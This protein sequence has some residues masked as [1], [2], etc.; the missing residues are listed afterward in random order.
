MKI[1]GQ[2]AKNGNGK[3]KKIEKEKEEK[4]KVPSLQKIVSKHPHFSFLNNGKIKCDLTKHEMQPSIENFNLYLKSKS[5]KKGVEAQYDISE[6]EEYLIPHKDNPDKLLFC[7]LT[8]AKISKKKSAIE[9]HVNGKKFKRILEKSN[10]L[11]I[12][13]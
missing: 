10:F 4:K 11:L 9:K 8:G 12:Y 13:S 6:Y 1:E 5:Y 2:K 7:Q 3:T